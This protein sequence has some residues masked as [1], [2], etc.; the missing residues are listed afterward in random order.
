MKKVIIALTSVL[1][2]LAVGIGALFFWEYRSKAQLEAQVEDYLGG[3]DVTA[4]GI[5]VHG[6]PYIL[7][8]MAERAELTYVDLAPQAQRQAGFLQRFADCGD[9]MR[10]FIGIAG[11]EG[12]SQLMVGWIDATAGK[13]GH[14]AGKGELPV[15]NLHQDFGRGASGRSAKDDDRGSGNAVLRIVPCV[16]IR[17]SHRVRLASCRDFLQCPRGKRI[18]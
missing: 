18:G 10:G 15:A 16:T 17:L 9:S 4:S 2:A 12:A 6:R 7:S 14:P 3:C 8:A 13:H 5:E 11:F 1:T